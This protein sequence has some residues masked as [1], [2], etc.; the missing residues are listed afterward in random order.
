MSRILFFDTETTGLPKMRT[1][2]A[3]VK[4]DNWPDLVSISWSVYEDKELVEKQTYI[5]KPTFWKI[6]D[7]SIK[8][9]GITNEMA[10]QKGSDLMVV[11]T[12]FKKALEGCTSV[13]AH[14]MEF[15]RNV[16]FNGFKWRLDLDPTNFWSY[17]AE[18]C[19][20][21]KAKAEMK[22][23]GKGFHP[24][25][26][27]KFIGLDE[28]YKDTFKMP[29]PPAAHTADRDVDVLQRVWFT[30]WASKVQ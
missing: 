2:S 20:M 23:L 13:I 15:D 9:H 10:N 7:E 26:P 29:A 25:D 11:L 28:L 12:M 27:Y 1:V 21:Q 17:G 19:T 3:L 14:N 16:V 24:G 22:V 30:R 5:I 8:F 18:V 6:P 4:P